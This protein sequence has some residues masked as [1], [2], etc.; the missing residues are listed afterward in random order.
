MVT[1]SELQK[2]L[3]DNPP[4]NKFVPYCLLS[5]E[6]D[7]LIVY[8]EGD[9]D[10]SHRL[11]D[12]ITLYLSLE[13]NE[14]VGCRIKGI[15][16]IL[17]DLPNFIRVNHGDVELSII[18]LAFRGGADDKVRETINDLAREATERNLVLEGQV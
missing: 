15:S 6:A 14:I 16:G 11:T 18:F 13:T 2:F 4:A 17:Q 3:K 12:H 7:A 9:A 1:K 8:F 10:Y 5:K